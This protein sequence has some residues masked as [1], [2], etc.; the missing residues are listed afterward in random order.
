MLRNLKY[1]LI[2]MLSVDARQEIYFSDDPVERI[3]GRMYKKELLTDK[4][5][6]PKE[7]AY[8]STS[9]N[10]FFMYMDD[11]LQNSG[12]AYINVVTKE[13]RKIN[14]IAKNKAT[15]VD[16]ETSDVYFGTENGLYKYDPVTHNAKDIGLYN[17]NIMKIVIRNNGMYILDANNHRIYK[18]YDEGQRAVL[19]GDM[20]TVADFEVDNKNNVHFVT[21]CGVFCFTSDGYVVKNDVLSI[22]Y[23]F[24]VGEN[25]VYAV[26]EE[27]LYNIDCRN[28]TAEKIA[29]LHFA[30]RS[31]IFGDYGDIFYSEDD[32]I[33]RL[34]PIRAYFIYRRRKT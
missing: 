29:D 5:D 34:K 32:N 14:G 9:R 28:G 33:Y 23:N 17:M 12:R 10:L 16:S 13:T 30:P 18:I 19:V 2:L 20:K 27:G 3:G 21:M 31:I 8:D 26:G 4:F 15:A 6:S 11:V 22:A 7:L 24:V 1:I 25:K